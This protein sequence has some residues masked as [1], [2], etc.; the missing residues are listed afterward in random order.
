M[1]RALHHYLAGTVVEASPCATAAA[2]IA[3]DWLQC[4]PQGLSVWKGVLFMAGHMPLLHEG[5]C[6]YTAQA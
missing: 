1:V 4:R 5:M 6:Y 3:G 2:Y